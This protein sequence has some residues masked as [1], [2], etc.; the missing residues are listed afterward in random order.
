MILALALLLSA[1]EPD[2]RASLVELQLERRHAA[3]LSRVETLI[4]EDRQQADEL[5]LYYLHGH[6]LE[7]LG[8]QSEAEQ[9]FASTLASTHPL[10]AYGR[11]RLATSQARTGHPEVAAGLLATLL[12][13]NPPEPL[14]G[15]ATRLLVRSLERG[16]DCRLLRRHRLWR[17][18]RPEARL[19]ELAAAD[20]SRRQGDDE[21]ALSGLDGLLTTDRVDDTARQAATRL[22]EFD[23]PAARLQL[24]V[25]MVLH[26]HRDFARSNQLLRTALDRIERATLPASEMSEAL[27]ALARN[28]FWLGDYAAAAAGFGALA[29]NPYPAERT[30]RALYQQGRSL[31]LQGRWS[32][33]STSYRR[34]YVTDPIGEW[35][36]T[37]LISTM[38]IEWRGGAEEEALE[39]YRLL[40]S[41]RQW[42]ALAA[43]AAIYLAASDIVRGRTDRAG[44]WLATAEGYAGTPIVESAF[45]RGRLTEAEGRLDQALLHYV[46]AMRADS[47]HPLGQAAAARLTGSLGRIARARALRQAGTRASRDL[48]EAWLVL[49]DSDPRGQ[50]ARRKLLE[51]LETDSRVAAVRQARLV[52]PRDWPLW[53]AR[54]RRPEEM[55]LALGL[56]RQGAP[57]VL[58]HFPISDISLAY[59]GSRLLSEGGRTPKSLYVADV[60][61]RRAP[62]GMPRRLLPD[63][64]RRLLYPFPY[65]PSITREADRRRTDPYLLAAIIREESRFDPE[66]LSNASARGL[67]QFILPT[68]RRLASAVELPEI[69]AADLHRPELSIAL[70]A[71]YLAELAELFGGREHIMVAAY[72]AGEPQARLWRSY[73]YSF[74]PAEYFSKVGFPQTRGY[75]AKV[76]S[77]RAQYSELYGG[78]VN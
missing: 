53:E 35:A 17:L 54:L 51:M 30:A 7:A 65:R 20:C 69:N 67:T 15:D 44:T 21:S 1:G 60:I 59:T 61:A 38:R 39:A 28:S 25:G 58:R 76:L 22:L 66:A 29:E 16:G 47:F 74:D 55:L 10:S 11:F 2:P 37:A 50:A 46:R 6:L 13:S 72:N 42:R 49:G 26:Q 8:R 23:P 45:W 40:R 27:Y 33:A 12:G 68:A 41:R 5:G 52:P 62:S 48:Y 24:K 9:A 32:D 71:A 4:E 31:E 14:I 34:A 75:L 3:A 64:L 18:P 43:R 70:G 57:A 36:A 19:I 73:C 56:W 77:S 63:G 78:L